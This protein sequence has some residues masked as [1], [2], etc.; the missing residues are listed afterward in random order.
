[1]N[2]TGDDRADGNEALDGGARS[3]KS[4]MHRRREQRQEQNQ[5]GKE[6]DVFE[7]VAQ[8]FIEVKSSTCAVWRLR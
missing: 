2:E 8:S 3:V 1:M 6:F 5:P 7:I 4:V